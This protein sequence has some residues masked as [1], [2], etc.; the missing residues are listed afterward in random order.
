MLTTFIACSSDQKDLKMNRILPRIAS[1]CKTISQRSETS[2]KGKEDEDDDFIP[3]TPLII[4]SSDRLR[5]EVSYGIKLNWPEGRVLPPR[6]RSH[7][8]TIIT[9]FNDAS[10]SC[11]MVG[12]A[13]ETTCRPNFSF[14]LKLQTFDWRLSLHFE[15]ENCSVHDFN[16]NFDRTSSDL[17]FNVCVLFWFTLKPCTLVVDMLKLIVDW[18]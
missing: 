13:Y 1:R 2:F 12:R 7:Y 10:G 15:W 17:Q 5:E 11:S 8:L 16:S 18:K 4:R 9:R 3:L 14:H 6:E